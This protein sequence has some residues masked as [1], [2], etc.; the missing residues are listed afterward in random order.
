MFSNKRL[1]PETKQD[2][3]EHS[4]EGV[5]GYCMGDDDDE[6]LWLRVEATMKTRQQQA[7]E[8]LEN[9][10]VVAEG[11]NDSDGE[12]GQ[13]WKVIEGKLQLTEVV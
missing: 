6:T 10:G 12:E 2:R 9:L 13:L 3:V 4:S 1:S 7:V 11:D 5:S 8:T